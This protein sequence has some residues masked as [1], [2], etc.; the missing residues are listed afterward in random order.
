LKSGMKVENLKHDSSPAFDMRAR[1]DEAASEIGRVVLGKDGQIRLA[2]CC[3]I[4]GGHLLLEDKPGMAKP[5]LSQALARAFGLA[6]SRIQFTSDL[7]PAD[8]LGVSVYDQKNTTFTF[9]KG[10]IFNNLILADEIN[11]TTPK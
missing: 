8:I 10:P 2:I 6:Y 1:V 5:T 3:M 11:R 7:L 4:A 9:H